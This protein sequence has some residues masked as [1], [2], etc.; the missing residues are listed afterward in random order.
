[1][2]QRYKTVDDYIEGSE[3]W[4]DELAKLRSALKSSKAAQ[5]KFSELTPGRQREYEEYVSSA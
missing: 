1:M 2:M 5:E 3:D 4:Q